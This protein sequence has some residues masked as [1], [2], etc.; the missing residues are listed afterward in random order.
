MRKLMLS[1]VAAAAMAGTL[2]TPSSA[3]AAVGSLPAIQPAII[4]TSITEDVQWRRCWHR[5]YS[6]VWCRYGGGHR[7]GWSRGRGHRYGWSRRW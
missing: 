1:L 5:P 7:Y 6:R 4:D 2:M 3:S